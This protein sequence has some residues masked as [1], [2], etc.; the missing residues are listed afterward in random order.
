MKKLVLVCVSLFALSAVAQT[1]REGKYVAVPCPPPMPADSTHD[2]DVRFYGADLSLPMTSGAMTA[3]L[4]IDLTPRHA[5]FDTFS[6][7]MVNLVC[8]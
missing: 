6:L 1:F 7:H 3:H 2:F 5:G 4:R 8:D